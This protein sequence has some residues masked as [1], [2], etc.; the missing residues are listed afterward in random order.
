MHVELEC[1]CYRLYFTTFPHPAPHPTIL[2][3]LATDSN[4]RP[5]IR[6]RPRAGPSSSPDDHASYYYFTI[7]DQLLYF[8]F[9]QDWGPLN[10]AM[11]YKACILIHELLEVTQNKAVR[12]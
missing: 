6:S 10:I 4:N 7:D 1:Y 8:S 9:F 3:G 12:V 2:N 11:V 5:R